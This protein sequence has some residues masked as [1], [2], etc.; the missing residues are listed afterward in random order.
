M[1]APSAYA[2]K[3][4]LATDVADDYSRTDPRRVRFRAEQQG[5]S[6]PGG[7]PAIGGLMGG[8]GGKFMEAPGS[9][10]EVDEEEE[11][12]SSTERVSCDY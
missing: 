11:Q 9:Q 12:E 10:V 1:L 2:K 5:G 8:L 4:P 3:R 7:P 6:L